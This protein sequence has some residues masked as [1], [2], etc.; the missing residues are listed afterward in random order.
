MSGGPVNQAKLLNDLF[1]ENKKQFTN[2]EYLQTQMKD[3]FLKCKPAEQPQFVTYMTEYFKRVNKAAKNNIP[4]YPPV[5][6]RPTIQSNDFEIR[7]FNEK[8]LSHELKLE[9]L[10]LNQL[11]F[12]SLNILRDIDNTLKK[13]H[14]T[15]LE[16]HFKNAIQLKCL[17]K[18]SI[19]LTKQA[20]E[21]TCALWE[22]GTN[23]DG[24][25]QT[26]HKLFPISHPLA[27]GLIT[28]AAIASAT[29]YIAGIALSGPGTF[30]GVLF[31]FLAGMAGVVG[32]ALG[33]AALLS[34]SHLNLKT[35]IN[36]LVKYKQQN[37]GASPSTK[38]KA[39][40]DK[41][42]NADGASSVPISQLTKT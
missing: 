17:D 9:L 28:L 13:D 36:A 40:F 11:Y 29:L 38:I 30:G 37:S 25:A 22:K 31:M 27:I 32:T 4:S 14:A 34:N 8:K 24:L 42:V 35:S 15:N 10:T 39:D 6:R 23:A 26:A 33:G 7:I 41:L 12:D 16:F 2:R 5:M 18:E 21:G 1:T 19:N 20:L 3:F